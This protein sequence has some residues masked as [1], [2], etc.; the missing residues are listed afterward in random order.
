[1]AIC[2]YNQPGQ[3]K[4]GL[5]YIKHHSKGKYFPQLPPYPTHTSRKKVVFY[6]CL[7]LKPGNWFCLLRVLRVLNNR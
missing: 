1:M 6:N 3:L 2:I 7:L 5:I 4:H